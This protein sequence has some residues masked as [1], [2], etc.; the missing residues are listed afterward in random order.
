MILSIFK[1]FFSNSSVM[2]FSFK[3]VCILSTTF[4]WMFCLTVFLRFILFFMFRFF[5]FIF[6]SSFFFSF[7]SSFWFFFFIFFHFDFVEFF[8]FADFSWLC[9]YFFF[10]FRCFRNHCLRQCSIAWSWL[11]FFHFFNFLRRRWI[12]RLKKRRCLIKM[13]Q[14]KFKK[15]VKFILFRDNF[16]VFMNHWWFHYSRRSFC[17]YHLHQKTKMRRNFFFSYFIV[18]ELIVEMLSECILKLQKRAKQSEQNKIKKSDA[19][20]SKQNKLKFENELWNKFLKMNFHV[21]WIRFKFVWV[22]TLN[23]DE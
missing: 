8:F 16:V 18:F 11:C 1:N 2:N 5:Q 10:R 21:W 4:F 19:I 12:C 14:K 20:N 9:F 13:F 15:I 23:H 22:D 3:N 7:V 6:F 17:F